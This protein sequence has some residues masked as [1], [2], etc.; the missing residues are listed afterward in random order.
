MQ[1][2]VALVVSVVNVEFPEYEVLMSFRTFNLHDRIGNRGQ[3]LPPRRTGPSVDIKR[4]AV[5][6]DISTDELTREFEDYVPDVIQTYQSLGSSATW[7]E[8]W[9]QSLRR[10]QRRSDMAR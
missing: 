6:F 10:V 3:I 1:N 9:V 5:F 4:L 2:W 8:A 7:L